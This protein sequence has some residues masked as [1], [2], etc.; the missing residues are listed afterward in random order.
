MRLFRSFIPVLA[1]LGA[2]AWSARADE[3]RNPTAIFAGIDKITGRITTF[4]VAIDETVQFGTLQITPRVCLTRPQTETPLTEGFV[5]VDDAENG[6]MKRIFSGWMFAASPGLHGVEHPVYDVWLKDCVG[7][8]EVT[9]APANAA[10][11]V[12]RAPPP[13]AAPAPAEGAP[14]GKASRTIKPEEPVEPTMDSL[15]PSP[16]DVDS[17]NM[18]NPETQAPDAAP[19]E[20]PEPAPA[21]PAPAPAQHGRHT[22]KPAP[23]QQLENPDNEFGPPVE[24]G[25]APGMRPEGEPVAPQPKPARRPKHKRPPPPNPD[26]APVPPADVPQP[27]PQPAPQ[28]SGPQNLLKNLPFMH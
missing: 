13:N 15:P 10:P 1:V 17:P 12:N 24:V 2:S 25:P 7:G 11:E 19:P 5:Q 21:A 20:P 14:A 9:P 22:G 27:A 3:I 18:Q 8:K 16:D 26:A 4:D 23:A 6:K 28:P